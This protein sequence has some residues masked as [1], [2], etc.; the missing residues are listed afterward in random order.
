MNKNNSKI[1]L[2][3]A[4]NRTVR[5]GDFWGRPISISLLNDILIKFDLKFKPNRIKLY[6]MYQTFFFVQLRYK[7]APTPG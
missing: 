7:Q 6:L 2:F 3:Y 5:Y 1:I 4:N